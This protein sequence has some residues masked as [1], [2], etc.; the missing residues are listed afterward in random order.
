[1]ITH[2]GEIEWACILSWFF[3]VSQV[4]AN[5]DDIYTLLRSS[6]L[7]RVHDK[8]TPIRIQAAIALSKLSGTEDA[9]ELGEGEPDVMEVLI[10][11]LQHDPAA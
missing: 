9:E 2:L 10:D 4:P 8:E 6:L 5:S 1:M 11:L 7:E 3:R